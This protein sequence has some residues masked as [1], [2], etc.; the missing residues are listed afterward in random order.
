MAIK[1]INIDNSFERFS[2][3][4]SPKIVSELNGQHVKLAHLEGD[5]VP[6]HIHDNE[7][8]LFWVIEGKLDVMERDSRVTLHPGE[9]CVIPAGREHRVLPHGH[10]KLV[11]FEPAEIAHTGSVES[12]ITKEKYDW[13]EG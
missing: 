9:L 5:K 1:V 8:E 13:L 6:W 11:L 4:F 12:E 2:D 10:V 3:L 7:D